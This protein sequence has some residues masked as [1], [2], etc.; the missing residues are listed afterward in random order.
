SRAIAQPSGAASAPTSTN[1]SSEASWVGP[2]SQMKGTWTIEA[3]GARVTQ[4]TD[5][6]ISPLK[7]LGF[8]VVMTNSAKL[9]EIVSSEGEIRMRYATQKAIIEEVTV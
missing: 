8:E 5:A 6:E 4:S 2:S 3:S 7:R 9:A 1:G